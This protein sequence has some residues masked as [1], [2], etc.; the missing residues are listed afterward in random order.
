MTLT[1][2]SIGTAKPRPWLPPDCDGDLLVDADHLAARVDQRPA[3]VALVDGGVGLDA[4][5]D[6]RAVGGLQ[7][8][9]GG[10]DDARGEREVVAER[11][12]DGD[13]GLADLAV[14]ELPSGSGCSAGALAGSTLST[15]TSLVSS[16]PTIFATTLVV[17]EPLPLKTTD[18]LLAALPLLE[19]TCALVRT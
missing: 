8:A 17:C 3:R 13:D 4:V 7:V 14:L 16:M 6:G 10:R 11:I 2:V 15:A 19:T 18:T 9:V 12:A 5:R 1:A